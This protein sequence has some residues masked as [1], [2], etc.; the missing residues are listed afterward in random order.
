MNSKSFLKDVL[1]KG[2]NTQNWILNR[3]GFRNLSEFKKSLS[4]KKRIL[5]AGCGNGKANALLFECSSF[6][7]KYL[8]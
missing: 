4:N 3:N 6:E 2:S 1:L 7:F 5:D 8:V